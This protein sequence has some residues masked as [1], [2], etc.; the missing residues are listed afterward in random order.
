MAIREAELEK[1]TKTKGERFAVRLDPQ[2]PGG[3]Y[4]RAGVEFAAGIDVFFDDIPDVIK[5]DPWLMV[6]KV[7][8]DNPP[9]YS[10]SD[11]R[12]KQEQRRV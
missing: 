11:R 12:V 3:M 6:A 7:E 10:T 8:G 1:E 4:R 9:S 2:H 5:N